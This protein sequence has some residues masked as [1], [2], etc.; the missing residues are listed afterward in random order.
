M[1]PGSTL[2]THPP[3]GSVSFLGVAGDSE[4]LGLQEVVKGMQAPGASPRSKGEKNEAEKET[5]AMSK[6]APESWAR[7]QGR[8]KMSIGNMKVCFW[9]WTALYLN[10]SSTGFR[11]WAMGHGS[12]PH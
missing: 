3:P 8:I 4:G 2:R 12:F 6:Q 9:S 11:V 1:H 7:P 10:L 5:E